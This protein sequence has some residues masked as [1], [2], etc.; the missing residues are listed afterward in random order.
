VELHGLLVDFMGSF[1]VLKNSLEEG[2]FGEMN[3]GEEVPFGH[4]HTVN[5]ESL[6]DGVFGNH[7]VESVVEPV[8]GLRVG[9]KF[10]IV[11]EAVL[12]NERVLRGHSVIGFS[13]VL[14]DI[15]EI[16]N[17]VNFL[18]SLAYHEENRTHEPDL[19]P[20]E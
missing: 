15:E 2:L 8:D 7:V 11:I 5:N 18:R 6:F 3:V 10:E 13:W 12:Q 16:L 14:L 17:D 1:E 20:E 19:V 4:V 9:F